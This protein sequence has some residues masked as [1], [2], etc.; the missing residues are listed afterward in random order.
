MV[1]MI[2]RSLAR[3]SIYIQLTAFVTGCRVLLLTNA[4]LVQHCSTSA[5]K[6]RKWVRSMFAQLELATK[7]MLMPAGLVRKAKVSM[8]TANPPA[9]RQTG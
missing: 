9:A 3:R 8:V 5:S 1:A 2:L 4:N 6:K 7:Y